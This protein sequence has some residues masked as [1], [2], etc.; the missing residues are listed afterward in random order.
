MLTMFEMHTL[1]IEIYVYDH[2]RLEELRGRS[3]STT[4]STLP[5]HREL[6]EKVERQ[7]SVVVPMPRDDSLEGLNLEVHNTQS[8]VD[9]LDTQVSSLHQDVATLSMEV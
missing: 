6:R 4:A 2:F 7:R 1:V 5:T 3:R 8:S 9:R